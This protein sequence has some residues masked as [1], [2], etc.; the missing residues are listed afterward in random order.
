ML[1]AQISDSH[2]LAGGKRLAGRFDTG[3]AFDR[4]IDSLAR[5]PVQPDLILFSGDLGEDATEEE[6]RHVAAGLG[7]L[8]RPVL[9]VPGNHD[10]RAPMLACLPEFLGRTPAGHLCLCDT[11][12]DIAVVGLDTLVEGAPHG[13]LCAE[14]LA[15]LSETLQHCADREV[16]IFMHHPPITTGM[17][18]M[19]SMGL[20]RGREELARLVAAHGRVKAILCGHMHRAILGTCGGV[21]VRV[22]PSASHQIAFDLREGTSFAFSDE[23]PQYMMHLLQPGT[24][25]VSHIVPVGTGA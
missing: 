5:Q 3:A 11:R 7:R 2:V 1:I 24:P 19:D 17:Q 23:P 18:D 10:A 12:F 15:W 16:L 14:R 6:Y 4:L 25:I 8:G 20:L 22:A 9:A 21:P 13:E